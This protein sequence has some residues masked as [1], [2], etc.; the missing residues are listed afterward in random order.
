MEVVPCSNPAQSKNAFNH[1]SLLQ[2]PVTAFLS[3]RGSS[4]TH[5]GEKGVRGCPRTP[6]SDRVPASSKTRMGRAASFLPVQGAPEQTAGGGWAGRGYSGCP[7][8]SERSCSEVG[9]L[10][11]RQPYFTL[12]CARGIGHSTQDSQ[13][14]QYARQVELPG[15][16]QRTWPRMLEQHREDSEAGVL[17]TWRPQGAWGRFQVT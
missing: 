16:G 7:G 1:P 4:P 8:S 14:S 15:S 5:S 17:K 6:T 12:P 11:W 2:I 10:N 13:A 3:N 9:V